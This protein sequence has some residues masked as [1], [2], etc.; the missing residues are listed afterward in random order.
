MDR[1]PSPPPPPDV[2]TGR[3]GLLVC[4]LLLLVA[5]FLYANPWLGRAD[6]DWPWSLLADAPLAPRSDVVAIGVIALA[7]ILASFGVGG[8]A[9]L[10][11]VVG[12]AS[13]AA[14][15]LHGEAY[16]FRLLA[17]ESFGLGGFAVSVVLGTGLLLLRR[18]EPHA[19]ATGRTLV[20]AGAVWTAALWGGTFTSAGKGLPDRTLV[21]EFVL[22]WPD[23]LAAILGR[24]GDAT[25]D[26]GRILAEEVVARAIPELLT[27]AAVVLGLV[28]AAR[29]RG[30]AGRRGAA[31]AGIAFAAFLVA[32]VVPAGAQLVDA[33]IHADGHRAAACFAAVADLVL[34]A[35]FGL[36]TVL[37][38]AIAQAVVGAPVAEGRAFEPGAPLGGPDPGPVARR[39]GF[40]VAFLLGL[41][42]IFTH[43]RPELGLFAREWPWRV[44]GG[45]SEGWDPL[46]AVLAA[47]VVFLLSTLAG[48]VARP[49]ARVARA[50]AMGC[51]VA[52]LVVTA[53]LRRTT[54]T[55]FV[56]F[57]VPAYVPFLLAG[58]ATGAA[59]NRATGPRR[60]VGAVAALALLALFFD[61][62]VP[63]PAPSSDGALAAAATPT[64]AYHS[65]ATTGLTATSTVREYFL[66][67]EARFGCPGTV[68]WLTALAIVVLASAVRPPGRLGRGVVAATFA[69]ACAWPVMQSVL[70]SAPGH[71]PDALSRVLVSLEYLVLA[72][73]VAAAA[74]LALRPGATPS[75]AAG[76]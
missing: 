66:G 39:A 8:R 24:G 55:P 13:F 60:V 28:A 17:V 11:A 57:R 21:H 41:A 51:G 43:F 34:P 64:G 68:F 33:A 42:S 56:Y 52:L 54:S 71:A 73:A 47:D 9:L 31:L 59:L 2:P 25:A 67:F 14:I 3:R 76:A 58:V 22:R 1:A 74:L 32:L 69:V 35:G 65:V 27:A 72:P 46:A 44:P 70:G 6:A 16:T 38:F 19:R 48:V 49:D 30:A 20:V 18:P 15:R 4:G 61:P 53:A 29:S 63:L 26:R 10:L 5:P 45:A 36:L 7:A 37:V 75:G 12:L 40:A 50:L 23:R 62:V